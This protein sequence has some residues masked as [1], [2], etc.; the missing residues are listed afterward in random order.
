MPKSIIVFDTETTGLT[1]P[2]LSNLDFQPFMT[3]IYACKLTSDFEFV[4][5][6]EQLIKPPVDIS[7]EITKITGI[8]NEMVKDAPDFYT[9]YPA[10]Y[11]FFCGVDIIVGQNVNFDINIL[12]YELMRHD[13][14]SKFCWAKRHICTIEASM[15]YLNK[16]MKLSDLHTF[17]FGESFKEAHRAKNDVMA[18]IRCFI[19]LVKRG[20]I[21]L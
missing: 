11:D 6:Y 19:E 14:Q 15:H 1:K 17:L 5:E 9:C 20:D 7:Q 16:R 21:E 10:L 12:T 3:E 4:G 8:S 13:L 18:T 2:A